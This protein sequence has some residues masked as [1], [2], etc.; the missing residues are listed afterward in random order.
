[1][2]LVWT[3]SGGSAVTLG[4]DSSKK[5]VIVETLDL[6]SLV[7]KIL[8]FRGTVPQLAPRGGDEGSFVAVIQQSFTTTDLASAYIK[9]EFAR[10]NQA[11]SLA[12]G[13]VATTFTFNGAVI[14]RVTLAELAGVKIRMRYSFGFASMS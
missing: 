10:V 5:T 14:Q 7:Q 13:R 12:W 3:P 9:S 4:D 2:N 1:M 6:P 8:Y 11:G